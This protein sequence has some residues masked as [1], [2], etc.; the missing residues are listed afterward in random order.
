VLPSQSGREELV[1]RC[2]ELLD[3]GPSTDFGRELIAVLA[4]NASSG[5]LESPWLDRMRTESGIARTNWLHYGLL[6]GVLHLLPLSQLQ[7]LLRDA[8]LDPGRLGILLEGRRADYCEASSDS[9]SATL[10]AIL[11]GDVDSGW[12]PAK[13]LIEVFAVVIDPRRYAIAFYEPRP[14]PLAAVWEMRHHGFLPIA[15]PPNAPSYADA[16]KC[17]QFVGLVSSLAARMASEWAS[18]LGLWDSLIGGAQSIFGERWA[19][20]RLANHAAA[21]KT[22]E[23][24]GPEF[25]DLFD[26]SKSLARRARY[27]RLRA[28]NAGWWRKQLASATTTEQRLFAALLFTTWGGPATLVSLAPD[29]DEVARSLSEA[30]WSR[31]LEAVE[32]AVQTNME[33]QPIRPLELDVTSLPAS[34]SPQA[35]VLLQVRARGDAS[36]EIYKRFL[37]EY[38]GEDPSVWEVCQRTAVRLLR[39]KSGDAQ[40]LQVIA[41]AYSKGVAAFARRPMREDLEHSLPGTAA[42]QIAEHPDKYPGYLVALAEAYWRNEVGRKITPVGKKAKMD[43]WFDAQ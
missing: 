25:T 22:S 29:L 6:L 12:R 33:R 41:K 39:G 13:R 18:D 32:V 4:D 28:G 21:Q 20:Y 16:E 35:A 36:V 1:A 34:L 27:A 26:S 24:P 31:L 37:R 23:E 15:T 7:D 3:G 8:P 40:Q 9:F 10:E 19:F 14:I 42:K 43:G 11:N 5:E 2:F 30:D 17:L 38:N